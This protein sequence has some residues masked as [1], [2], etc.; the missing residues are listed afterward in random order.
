MVC[1]DI[2][3]ARRTDAKWRHLRKLMMIELLSN[4]RLDETKHI[5]DSEVSH[6]VCSIL[7]ES[8][9]SKLTHFR[10]KIFILTF[11]T[12]SRM[13]L[14]K[15]F[16]EHDSQGPLDTDGVQGGEF[17]AL[18]TEIFVVSGMVFLGD[19]FPIFKHYDVQGCMS[20]IKAAHA[21]LD[22]FFQ[23]VLDEHRERRAQGVNV[24]E[25]DMVDILLSSQE[26]VSDL[27][28]KT[29]LLVCIVL[30]LGSV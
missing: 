27:N 7:H 14:K 1:T 9:T 19:C 10:E 16:L 4:K 23:Q 26:Q 29:L 20:R 13:A 21:R 5:R 11:N 30:M 8:Q 17:K 25:Q 2:V 6:M 18:V 12:I 15:R 24:G 28:I 22:M 3:M